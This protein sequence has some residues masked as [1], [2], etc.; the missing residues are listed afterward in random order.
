MQYLL[1]KTNLCCN[2]ILKIRIYSHAIAHCSTQLGEKKSALTISVKI[3]NPLS[4]ENPLPHANF[5]HMTSLK[6]V[7]V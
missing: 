4:H 6:I 7:I 5:Q 1:Y 3:L 2:N